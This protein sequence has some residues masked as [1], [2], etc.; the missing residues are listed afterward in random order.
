MRTLLHLAVGAIVRRGDDV[1][2]VCQ[3][4]DEEG[5]PRWQI[6]G[7]AVE[8]GEFAEQAVV[9]ELREETGLIATAP[10]RLACTMQYPIPDGPYAGLWTAF[11]FAFDALEGTLAPRD[12]DGEVTEAVWVPLAEAVDRLSLLKHPQLRDPEIRCLLDGDSAPT[13]WTWPNGL[14]QDPLVFPKVPVLG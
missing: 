11:L 7:G 3:Q 13:Y 12:P 5:I 6:P 1:L 8:P 4:D 14:A 2:M 9:R 10:D